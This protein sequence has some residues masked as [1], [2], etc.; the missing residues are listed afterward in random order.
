MLSEAK[1]HI[2]NLGF[3][4]TS[5]IKTT[6][7]M[8]DKLRRT[9]GM[10]LSRMQDVAGAR[11]V[12]RDLAAQDAARD[13]IREF[14]EG[15]G[16]QC[17]VVDRRA[18]PRFGYKAVHVVVQVHGMP[19]E[20]QIRTELQDAWAQIV[21]RLADRWGRG[22]R[23]GED[24]ANPDARVRSGDLQTSR[25]G[26]VELLMALSDAFSDV[27]QGRARVESDTAALHEIQD[28]FQEIS[29]PP[30]RV[31]P[32]TWVAEKIPEG[33]VPSMTFTAEILDRY[34]AR[35]LDPA[36]RELLTVGSGATHG[37]LG[38]AVGLW[39]GFVGE[40]LK[41]EAN[42]LQNAEQRLR[43]IL[44]LVADATDEGP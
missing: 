28:D 2:S 36:D 13:T 44:Q 41:D 33:L 40:D 43:S 24:P 7:T 12:V 34:S 14:F 10:E 32:Q 6:Q 16:C 35:L 18:D 37:Q 4:P 11:I 15:L 29:R 1:T 26:A 17:R 8:T 3:S 27:E 21:E 38:R 9:P 19:L 31:D 20:V 22:I 5:R 39:L 30:K 23:Y 42:R 25:R